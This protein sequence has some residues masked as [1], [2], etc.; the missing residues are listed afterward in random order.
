MNRC[1]DFTGTTALKEAALNGCSKIAIML[2]EAGAGVQVLDRLHDRN[3]LG[4][5]SQ[6]AL[7]YCVLKNSQ[8]GVR[9]L[10]ESGADVNKVDE[11]GNTALMVAARKDI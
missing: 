4:F 7:L 1:N 2:I 11:S 8:K 3:K 5:Q 10:A 9:M 6:T